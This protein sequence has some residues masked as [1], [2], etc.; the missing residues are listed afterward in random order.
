MSDKLKN[1]DIRRIMVGHK[2]GQRMLPEYLPPEAQNGKGADHHTELMGFQK[3]F[4]VVIA[5]TLAQFENGVERN[6][7]AEYLTKEAISQGGTSAG[8]YLRATLLEVRDVVAPDYLKNVAAKTVTPMDAATAIKALRDGNADR[9][10][11][12]ILDDVEK[13]LPK[14]ATANDVTGLLRKIGDDLNSAGDDY[15]A[16]TADL[17]RGKLTVASDK[18]A[19]GQITAKV[20][21]LKSTEMPH[22]PAALSR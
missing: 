4:D 8:P 9:D 17:L 6:A 15:M 16:E 18:H 5:R 13:Q 11:W 12:N 22:R 14:N 2:S 20:A 1:D 21:E 19:D 10:A 3:D 7:F